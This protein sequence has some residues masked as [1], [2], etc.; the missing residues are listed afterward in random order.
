METY[1]DSRVNGDFAVREV[2]TTARGE[3]IIGAEIVHVPR[4]FNRDPYRRAHEIAQQISGVGNVY[5]AAQ[6]TA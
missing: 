6:R 4:A 2:I 5:V 1:I 3:R